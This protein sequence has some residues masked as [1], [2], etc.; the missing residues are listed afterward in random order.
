MFSR[1]F[2][3]FFNSVLSLYCFQKLI[4]VW[5]EFAQTTSDRIFADART[6]TPEAVGVAA[7]SMNASKLTS[8]TPTHCA[9][10]HKVRIT[11]FEPHKFLFECSC[12]TF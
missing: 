11:H 8:A 7:T 4:R 10:I 3:V 5:T 2:T 12:A 1:Q 9:R 6:D